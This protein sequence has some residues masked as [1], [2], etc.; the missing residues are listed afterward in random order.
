MKGYFKTWAGALFVLGLV[1]CAGKI[2]LAQDPIEVG[3]T[4]YKLLFDNDRV[5]VMEITFKPGDTIA[6]HWHPDHVV[7][8]VAG[9]TLKL[10]YPDGTSKEISG[11]AGQAFWIPSE[12][13]AAENVGTTEVKGIVIEIKE[14]APVQATE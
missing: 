10:T 3:P 14:A 13:H 7:T 6:I 12:S 9:G 1:L 5:R 11:Q 8:F 4:I 2:V